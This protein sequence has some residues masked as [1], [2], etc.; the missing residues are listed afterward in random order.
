MYFGISEKKCRLWEWHW[1]QH[2]LWRLLCEH[3]VNEVSTCEFARPCMGVS[4]M[5]CACSSACCCCIYMTLQL[6]SANLLVPHV[7][8]P[9]SHVCHDRC[10]IWMSLLMTLEVPPHEMHP[11]WDAIR[12]EWQAW[13]NGV[14]VFPGYMPIL[15]SW[16][17]IWSIR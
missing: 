2:T 13:L 9:S 11:R 17:L 8:L 10:F 3:R 16:I 7:V 12:Y 5:G 4:G 6:S 14:E 1:K 15:N